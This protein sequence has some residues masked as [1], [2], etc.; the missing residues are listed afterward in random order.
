MAALGG[1]CSPLVPNKSR[2]AGMVCPTRTA[3]QNA[4][5]AQQRGP[6]PGAGAPLAAKT[7]VVIAAVAIKV[8]IAVLITCSLLTH[9]A[10]L[11][12]LKLAPFMPDR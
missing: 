1:V 8:F 6:C 3:A 4:M 9:I 11:M 5:P 2:T 10:V 7:V 12:I